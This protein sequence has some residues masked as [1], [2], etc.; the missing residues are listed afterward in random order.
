[1]AVLAPDVA[2]G[3][4][5][6]ALIGELVA[7]HLGRGAL[8]GEEADAERQ[9]AGQHGV[10][11]EAAVVEAVRLSQD[12]SQVQA[13]LRTIKAVLELRPAWHRT[14]ERVQAHLLVASLE[15]AIDRALE[16]KLRTAAMQLNT[17]AA[18]VAMEQVNP[19]EVEMRRKA[20]KRGVCVNT[21][22]TR[23]VL[24]APGIKPRAPHPPAGGE[25]TAHC[26]RAG[27]MQESGP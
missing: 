8:Q 23:N 21:K 3:E 20:L 26:G 9:Q 25:L 24:R 15:P 14:E 12:P 19:V 16:R 7:N 18:W 11:G 10:G 5:F 13:A 4:S 6:P 2:C 1:M 27:R 17:R 22:E